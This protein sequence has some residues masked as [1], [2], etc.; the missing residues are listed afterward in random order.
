MASAISSPKKWLT[1]RNARSI[2]AET[3]AE[4]KIGSTIVNRTS[5]RI[6][7]LG[8]ASC[9]KSKARQW[10]VASRPSNNPAL[11]SRLEPVHTEA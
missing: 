7:V 11:P 2:P 6:L 8:A 1:I 4:V 5:L 10:V 9:R 3:P